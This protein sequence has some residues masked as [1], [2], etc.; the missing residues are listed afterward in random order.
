[1]QDGV[2]EVVAVPG[3][4]RDE[5]V[6]AQGQVAQFGRG[7]IGDDVTGIDVVAHHHQ[8]TLVDAGRLVRTLELHQV[9]DIDA[10]LGRIG[11]SRGADH[12]AGGVNL[13]HDTSTLGH[14]S[15]AGI[16]GHDRLHAGAHERCFG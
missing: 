6:A 7:T 13:V 9:V 3:H 8:R 12:D 4:E 5:H 11:F 16:T 10:R 15:G 1:E 14:D 2:F